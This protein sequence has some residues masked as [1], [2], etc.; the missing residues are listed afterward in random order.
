MLHPICH[1]SMPLVSHPKFRSRID[2]L[3]LGYECQRC[4]H[5]LFGLM[6]FD[7]WWKEW[8]LMCEMRAWKDHVEK[9]KKKMGRKKQWQ[10]ENNKMFTKT[11]VQKSFARRLPCC[12]CV[13]VSTLF[14][15]YAC[16]VCL[17]L[18]IPIHNISNDHSIPVLCVEIWPCVW[19]LYCVCQS[20]KTRKARCTTYT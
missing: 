10:T 18:P 14:V 15:W 11:T 19:W 4:H 16:F 17:Y 20:D 13:F 1:H 12:V 2:H 8:R 6:W 5:E 3:S 9:K 7:G